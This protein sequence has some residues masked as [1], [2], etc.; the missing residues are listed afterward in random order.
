MEKIE[1]IIEILKGQNLKQLLIE[2]KIK[3]IKAS[4]LLC[5]KNYL[6][7]EYIKTI[8]TD[9]SFLLVMMNDREIYYA[10]D[11]VGH[12]QEISDSAIG[13]VKEIIYQN[14][15]YEL[16]NANDYQ[17]VKQLYI[18]SP[19][20]IE[21]ECRFSDYFPTSGP[22]EFLSL[23]WLVRTGERADVNPKLIDLSEIEIT[24]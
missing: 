12:I 1:E 24:N 11:V 20:D 2:G 19:L 8:F 7:M 15:R 14:R 16:G 23:G 5:S 3:T 13:N 17:F 22:K 10:D 6:D 4:I 9:E 18:G 21:G